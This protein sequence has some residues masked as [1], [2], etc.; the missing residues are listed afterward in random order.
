MVNTETTDSSGLTVVELNDQSPWVFGV[1]LL[2]GGAA[3]FEYG[4]S[5]KT[6]LF[7]VLAVIGA[8]AVYVFSRKTMRIVI[9]APR[10]ALRLGERAIPFDQI[11]RAE[12]A[13]EEIERESPSDARSANYRVDVVLRSGD[14]VPISGFGEFNGTDWYRLIELINTAVGSKDARRT[15]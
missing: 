4:L 6:F 14:R 12:L 11:V 13:A 3:M 2:A 15:A 8:F 1:A 7:G 10:R 5:V 9:D